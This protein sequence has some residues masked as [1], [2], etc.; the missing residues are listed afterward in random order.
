MNDE[1]TKY[2]SGYAKCVSYVDTFSLST[3][4][5]KLNLCFSF[6]RQRNKL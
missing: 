2:H 4:I 1:Y 5:E 6:Q 3:Y